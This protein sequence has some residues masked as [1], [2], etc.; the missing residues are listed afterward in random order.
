MNKNFIYSC[1]VFILLG[2]NFP[3]INWGQLVISEAS[4]N[5][6]W[7][8]ENLGMVDWIE[9][10]NDGQVVIDLE[11]YQLNDEFDAAE[12]WI[13]PHLELEPGGRLMLLASGQNRPYLAENWRC[14]VLE[15]DVWHYHVGPTAPEWN[16]KEPGADLNSWNTGPG[17]FGY[18]DGDDATTLPDADVIFLRKSFE[19][20]DVN[21]WGYMSFA[22]DYDD[23]Y[24]AFLNGHEIARSAS[25]AGLEGNPTDMALFYVEAVLYAGDQPEQHIWD[26]NGFSE[27]LVEGE[28]V[29]AVQVHNFNAESSDLSIRPFLGLTRKD[30]LA[31]EWPESPAWWSEYDYLMHTDF[32]LATGES[33]VLYDANGAMVDALPIHPELPFGCSVGR[34]EG[35][36]DDWC[37][38]E[39]PT[40]GISNVGSACF[41][42]LEE[43]PTFTLPSGWYE[44]EVLVQLMPPSTEQIVRYTT[45]GDIPTT[46]SPMFPAGGLNLGASS[47]LSAKA[48]SASGNALPSATRDAT[49]LID[50]FIPDVPTFSIITEDDHLWDWNDGIYIMG[51][52]ASG[53]Y[54]HFGANFWQPWSRL[55][56]LQFF[57]VGGSLEV[58]A[59]MDLEI[60]GG[61]SRA[62]PQRSFRLDFKNEY[63][64]NFEWSLFQD[65]PTLSSF[66]NINLRNAGQHSWATKMQDGVISRMALQTHNIASAWEPVSAYVNGEYWGLY[67]AR[68][69]LDEWFVA[70]HF[71]V[72]AETVDFIGPF[73]V[74][75]G[76]DADFMAAANALMTTPTSNS[77]YPALFE[78][79]FDV[80]NY[81]DYFIFETYAQNTDWIGI[82]WGLNNVKLFRPSPD[83]TW[84]Y[85]I[86]DMDAGFGYFGAGPWSNFIESARNPGFPNVH[87]NL[88][89]RVLQNETIQHRFINRYADLVNTLFQTN[90]FNSYVSG[91]MDQISNSMPHH[92][93]R[94]NSPSSYTTWLN[95]INNLTTHNATRVGT[96]RNHLMDSFGLP[97]SHECTLDVFPPLAGQ[98]RINTIQPG[99]LPWGGIYFQECPVEIEA[100]A[101]PGYLFDQWDINFHT[102]SGAMNGGERTNTVALYISDLF[103]ARFTECPDDAEGSIQTG[104]GGG[105]AV[106]TTNVPY[107]DSVHW[108]IDQTF[109]QSALEFYPQESANYHAVVYFDGCT[110]QTESTWGES[111]DMNEIVWADAATTDLLLAP[112]PAN[113]QVEWSCSSRCAPIE[114]FNALGQVVWTESNPEG[115]I[116][117]GIIPTAE[118]PEG[119]YI[120]HSG[121]I[122][123]KL[124]IH[125]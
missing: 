120:V 7:M 74:L 26:A 22:A 52:N 109:V 36:S 122:V 56:R 20:E 1:F 89:D 78:S 25:M 41:V 99:P 68:E 2:I 121:P 60:H 21:D 102:S 13:F 39:E 114:V 53:E 44:D 116:T 63:G 61:W 30:G 37:I 108:F 91:A 46:A 48:W 117:Q 69:K 57:E 42:G 107:V 65:Q 85:V 81:L 98:V 72:E 34:A 33:V 84:H 100:I 27:W 73:A 24:I 23:G 90:S 59:Q 83:H 76:S 29:L 115:L 54:P 93:D 110:L 35:V 71:G 31:A 19:I 4:P 87:S 97:A 16:W 28:N 113:E 80:E 12:T 10:R 94:W 17:G 82:A 18:G 92:I 15:S 75:N 40:P 88:F 96:S 70:D 105:L 38:F 6:G 64:G 45:N 123:K 47:V 67:G 79:H 118:W 55:S 111:V 5:G 104:E 43:K 112:N 101:A 103:R 66:N 124:M 125:H 49:Y 8:D 3:K 51:P 119:T 95:A 11:G 77:N 62:E 86:Y 32:Q 50:E 14:P 58:E 106:S 9:L